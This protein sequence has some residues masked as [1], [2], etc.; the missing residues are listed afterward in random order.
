[1]TKRPRFSSD[2]GWHQDFRYW[3]FERPDL[4]SLWIALGDEHAE[5]GGL[6]LLPG[7]HAAEFAADQFDAEQF[8]DP[9]HRDFR[10]ITAE[11]VSVN[12]A[13]GDA[14]FFHCMTFHS[15]VTKSN[16]QTEVLGRVYVPQQR[17]SAAAG[18]SI[19]FS[20]GGRYP[21]AFAVESESPV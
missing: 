20:A 5:N 11:A 10:R 4:I 19:G 7:T 9:A 1:M 13:A 15:G 6:K 8:L 17:Q 21:I 18:Q 3:S 16:G 12:L 2:T 14:L